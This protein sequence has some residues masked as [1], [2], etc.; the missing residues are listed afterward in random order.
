MTPVR[1]N[2]FT[3]STPHGPITIVATKR[4]VCGLTLLQEEFPGERRASEFTNRAATQIQEYLAGR[5]RVFEV[6]L[7]LPGSAFQKAVWAEVCAIP[8]GQTRTAAEIADM[9]GKPGA[10]RSVGM[11]VKRNPV[12][13]I[14][15]A[16]RIEKS[17]A[18]GQLAKVY[19]ALRALE[20]GTRL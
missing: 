12:A 10:H 18:T 16:H 7:D 13:I 14:V 4:G 5:R 19:R 15:P 6:P 17:S 3:Y 2:Y 20:S 9:I 11:A 1:T 8:Y